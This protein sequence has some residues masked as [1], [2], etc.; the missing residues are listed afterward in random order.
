M[1]RPT[2]VS[3]ECL[4]GGDASSFDLIDPSHPGC[5]DAVCDA[6]SPYYWTGGT[7]WVCGFDD[8][9]PLTAYRPADMKVLLELHEQFGRGYGSPGWHSGY[10]EVIV[11][12]HK[13]NARLPHA[14]EAFFVLH[15]QEAH[16]DGAGINVA[17]ARQDFLTLYKLPAE[18]VP[19]LLLDPANW[20]EPFTVLS[21]TV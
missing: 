16:E 6:S 18:D 12:S 17:K 20:P 21:V 10:N 11:S 8:Q 7:R 19:L 13:F 1:L 4:Y 5:N 14:I 15:E 9:R 2:E 3:L